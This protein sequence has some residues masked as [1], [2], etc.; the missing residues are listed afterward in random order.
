[1]RCPDCG[2][3][4]GPAP[5]D[6]S[7]SNLLIWLGVG[8]IVLVLFLVFG[9][10]IAGYLAFRAGRSATAG[11]IAAVTPPNNPTDALAG[12][13]DPGMIRVELAL[14]Y[15][16]TAPVDPALQPQIA[17]EL[18]KHLAW[19]GPHAWG[20]ADA[21]VTWATQKQVPALIQA[22][23]TGDSPIRSAAY[24]ALTRLRDPRALPVFANGLV[25]MTT[26]HDAAEALIAIGPAAESDV[27]PY[28]SH[29]DV[30][31]RMEA[32]RVME[33]IGTAKSLPALETAQARFRSSG[34]PEEL[35]AATMLGHTIR[36]IKNRGN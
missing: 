12:L 26:R 22:A 13:Q 28:V 14:S 35:T 31:V 20:A 30:F 17:A 25:E 34:I 10:G 9:A 18:E 19:N 2:R 32:N 11:M 1:M 15:L 29:K 27:V 21:L 3:P 36:M 4:N 23:Q 33:K 16:K 7:G 5:D 6:S 8:A 24:K